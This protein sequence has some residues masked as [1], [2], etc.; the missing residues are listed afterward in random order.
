M[1]TAD[2]IE[3]VAASSPQEK[4]EKTKEQILSELQEQLTSL[5]NR[6]SEVLENN[7]GKDILNQ[8]VAED[9]TYL[10][11][12][13]LNDDLLFLIADIKK[14]YRETYPKMLAYS[15]DIRQ[16]TLH[17]SRERLTNLEEVLIQ[18]HDLRFLITKL[19]GEEQLLQLGDPEKTKALLDEFAISTDQL[20]ALPRAFDYFT[21]STKRKDE[22]AYEFHSRNIMVMAKASSVLKQLQLTYDSIMAAPLI[23]EKERKALLFALLVPA[24]LIRTKN[25]DR[26]WPEEFIEYYTANPWL[27][28]IASEL[29][30]DRAEDFN[31]PTE[32]QL[33]KND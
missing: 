29:F 14:T 4:D 20:S 17:K 25:P 30:P 16:D 2:Q 6:L 12:E 13:T 15:L 5:R 31:P 10:F 26:H 22:D 32:Q 19:F 23:S 3:R 1:S 33:S 7:D 28:E 11:R 21:Q 27:K 18:W 8:E 9:L 24:Q